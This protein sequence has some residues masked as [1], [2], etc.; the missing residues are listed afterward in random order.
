MENPIGCFENEWDRLLYEDSLKTPIMHLT[1][2]ITIKLQSESCLQ[3][4]L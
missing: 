1:A 3:N 4:Y 2:E